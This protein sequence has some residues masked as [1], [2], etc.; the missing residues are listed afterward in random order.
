MRHD[1]RTVVTGMAARLPIL[2]V[3]GSILA[4]AGCNRAAPPTYAP[5]PT[6]AYQPAPPAVPEAEKLTIARACAPDIERFC[7]GVP[8]RQGL[9]K[10]CMKAHLT[11]L[12]AG[13]F[14]AVMSAI[15]SAHAP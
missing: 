14:D 4:L 2:F 10:Q 7:A 12:S 9:I 11:E 6:A 13:C 8:P 3:T 5:P 1:V 15:A